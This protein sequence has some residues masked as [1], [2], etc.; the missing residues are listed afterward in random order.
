[1]YFLLCFTS[2]CFLS[3]S[4]L[5]C[6][7]YLL[8]SEWGMIS[9]STDWASVEG[10]SFSYRPSVSSG[11]CCPLKFRVHD[12]ALAATAIFQEYSHS[13]PFSQAYVLQTLWVSWDMRS[14]LTEHS[15]TRFLFEALKGR[16]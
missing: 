10:P 1:M 15:C 7:I 11:V 6:E 2:C 16:L 13:P 12:I 8:G 5:V 4:L 14:K 9:E 3:S